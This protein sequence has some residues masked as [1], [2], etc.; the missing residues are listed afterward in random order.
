MVISVVLITKN[1]EK[2]VAPCLESVRWADEL[3]VIDSFSTD[4]TVEISRKFTDKVFQHEWPGMVGTQRNV[5]LGIAVSQWVLFLDAD[6]R[7]TDDLKDEILGFIHSPL[8]ET[9]AAGEI[10]RKNY[11]FGKW[12]ECSYPNYTRRL[13]KKGAG[14]Y[15]EQPGLGF[16]SMLVDRGSIYRFHTPLEHLTSE[17]L[18]QR[19]KKIDF[20]S[21]LQADE[22][23]RAG[24]SA[25]FV[26]IAIN[27]FTNFI[28]VYFVKKG[29]CEGVPGFLY[30]VLTSFS[31]FLKYAKLWERRHSM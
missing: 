19:C 29:I 7:V 23:F 5:G 21:S 27:P 13:L 12:L 3:I 25:S 2:N 4:Q 6:E 14:H 17:T 8:A 22:K 26:N 16:D 10:P 31:T 18:A 9:Y 15:N 28:K 11:F 20:D 1:E 24:K 30:A